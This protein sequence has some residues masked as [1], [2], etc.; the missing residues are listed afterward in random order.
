[1]SGASAYFLVWDIYPLIFL[2][3]LCASVAEKVNPKIILGMGLF[4]FAMLW[5]PFW[6][7]RELFSMHTDARIVL[8]F[9]DCETDVSEWPVFP[10]IGLI[11]LGYAVGYSIR[12]MSAVDRDSYFPMVPKEMLLVGCITISWSYSV[13]CFLQNWPW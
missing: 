4:G 13:G 8:G 7:Y 12:K 9:A 5:I 3:V 10:W 6:D 1:M 2:G 11:W